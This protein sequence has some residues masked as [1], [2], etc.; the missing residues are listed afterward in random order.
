MTD[1]DP[2]ELADYEPGDARPL[3]SVARRRAMR[4]M[5]ALGLT[6]LLL[7]GVLVTVSTQIATADAACR[8]VVGT[9]DPEAVDA[10]ARFEL[11]GA[12]GPGWYCYA[13]RF[14]GSEI[15]LRSLGLIPGLSPQRDEAPGVPA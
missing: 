7:P 13:V 3:R 1:D 10:I 4:I 11:A 6:G 9:E 2:R 8:F 14:G 5:V 12:E 15:L